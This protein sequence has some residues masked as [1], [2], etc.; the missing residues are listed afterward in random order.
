VIATSSRHTITIRKAISAPNFDQPCLSDFLLREHARWL[1][2]CFERNDDM[3]AV[4]HTL[5]I[6]GLGGEVLGNIV[7]AIHAIACDTERLLVSVDALAG[8]NFA[9]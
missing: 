8:E 3:L 9:D 6:E 4:E 5:A 1:F 2:G 7:R